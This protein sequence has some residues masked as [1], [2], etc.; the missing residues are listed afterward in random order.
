MNLRR[1]M[2]LSGAGLLLFVGYIG[3]CGSGGTGNLTGGGGGSKD[4]CDGQ[5]PDQGTVCKDCVT[6]NCGS[7]L[8]D[9]CGALHCETLAKEARGK[10]CS[11]AD[12]YGTMAA[13][14]PIKAVV[15][16]PDIGGGPTGAG[17][18]AA[19]PLI[20]CTVKS[21]LAVCPK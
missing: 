10:M 12:C 8:T 20:E 21:C 3:G 6:T 13:P 1:F 14:G 16:D 9:C 17:W 2:V 11:G 18:I 5:F 7:Q 4:V 19:V 15:D